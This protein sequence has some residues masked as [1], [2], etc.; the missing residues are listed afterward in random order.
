VFKF[1][2]LPL[3]KRPTVVVLGNIHNVGVCLSE[4][5]SLSL[6]TG[7]AIDFRKSSDECCF[8]SLGI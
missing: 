2:D 6:A 7:S 5:Y 1:F 4:S 8:V 3:S